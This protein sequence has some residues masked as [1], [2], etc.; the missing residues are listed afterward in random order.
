LRLSPALT[1]GVKQT[2]AGN[3]LVWRTRNRFW[4]LMFAIETVADDAYR[5]AGALVVNNL[6][7]C[8]P[9][10][11]LRGRMRLELLHAGFGQ[12]QALCEQSTRDSQ[13]RDL[14]ERMREDAFLDKLEIETAADEEQRRLEATRVYQQH[15]AIRQAITTSPSELSPILVSALNS[16]DACIYFVSPQH[17]SLLHVAAS[18]GAVPAATALVNVAPDLVT[19][20]DEEGCMPLHLAARGDHV[21][22]IEVLAGSVAARST[23]QRTPLH[24]AAQR[25]CIAFARAL[26]NRG[27]D[28]DAADEDGRTPL[29]L[30]A[31]NN[32]AAVCEL[33]AERG[34]NQHIKA[35]DGKSAVDVLRTVNRALVDRL[36][37]VERKAGIDKLVATAQAQWLAQHRGLRFDARD[38]A[39]VERIREGRF[40]PLSDPLVK[41]AAQ[42]PHGRTMLALGLATHP[43]ATHED[44]GE[45]LVEQEALGAQQSPLFLL[46][47][48]RFLALRDGLVNA[49]SIA[50]LR[51]YVRVS[52]DDN[53]L[54]AAE[55]KLLQRAAT[56]ELTIGARESADDGAV[57]PLESRWTDLSARLSPA[58]RKP[59]DELLKLTGLDTVKKVALDVYAS[60]L[61][62][63]QLKAA[64]HGKAVSQETLNF[65]FLG[66]P[67]TGKTTVARLFAELLEQAGARAGHRFVQMT[68]SQAL[69]KGAKTFATEMAALTGSSKSVGPPP[70]PLRRGA[71]VEVDVGGKRYPAEI[72][73][74]D[75]DKKVYDVKFTDNTVEEKVAEARVR[76]VGEGQAVGGVLFLDEA[77]DLDPANNAEGR[78]ILAEIMSVAEDHRD[79]V[80]IILAG[81][82]D[83][84][85]NKLYAFNA[86]LP[87]RFQT[88][89][90]DDFSEDQLGQIWR[91]MGVEQG[92]SID[93]AVSRVAAARI[94]RGRGRK[95]FGNARSVRQMFERAI[96]EA[97]HRYTGGKPTMIV[98][99][100][101]GKEPTR[102]NV[103]ALDAVMR[104]LEAMVGLASVKRDMQSLVDLAR[105]NYKRELAGLK[106]DDVP[107]NR[108][109]LGNP[110]TGKTTVASLY[111]R[112][113][114]A[115]RFLSNGELVSKTASDF[116]GDVVGASQQKT[117]ALLEVAKGRV[118]LIDEAYVL[119]DSLYGKQALDTI[120][121]KVS[122]APGEDI[123]VVMCGYRSEMT[124]MLRDQ[125]P[126]LAR[127]FDVNFALQFDDLSDS[128]LL[129]VFTDLC[130]GAELRAPYDVRLHA[131]GVLAK[132]KRLP[133]FGNVGAA[134]TLFADAKK[135]MT[136]RLREKKDAPRRMTVEDVDASAELTR[137]PLQTLEKELAGRGFG[138]VERELRELGERVRV[139]KSEGSSLDGL[140]GNYI[141]TGAAGT[142]KTSVARTLGKILFA[143]GLLA[144]PDV[145]E[146]SATDLIG[147]YVGHSRKNVEEMMKAARGG[148]LFIDE[149]YGLGKGG[150]FTDEA[151]DQLVGMLTLPEYVGGKTVVI[152]A[153]YT[154]EMHH[155]LEK[156]V[157]LKS[158]FTETIPF[159][160]WA[161]KRCAELVVESLG[162]GAAPLKLR[163]AVNGVAVLERTFADL[164]ERPGWAN[165]RDA[166]Q[167]TKKVIDARLNRVAR[168][169]EGV[170]VTDRVVELCDIEEACRR[171]LAARPPKA[172]ANHKHGGI[173]EQAAA[174]ATTTA[175][176]AAPRPKQT[177]APKPALRLKQTQAPKP[178]PAV[179][180]DVDDKVAEDDDKEVVAEWQDLYKQ[181]GANAK[182][183][184]R[185][186]KEK[187]LDEAERAAAE[188]ELRRLAELR[189][190]LEELA[191]LEA[192]ARAAAEA[193]LQRERK[194]QAVVAKLRAMGTCEMGYC[195][196]AQG[197]GFRCAG[198]SHFVSY[199]HV[200]VS[201]QEARSMF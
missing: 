38:T 42:E 57:S 65:A 109:F 52:L 107:L 151:V 23:A 184:N 19:T 168:L 78:A 45:L 136:V 59:M 120:V 183:I 20:V 117:A 127:R 48:A 81:Y 89:Q 63:K 60:V 1:R 33:L 50:L 111:G 18:V 30:A 35:R 186:L 150:A 192:A 160:D 90:F 68:A 145:V 174:A 76:P 189:R 7:A 166:D 147:A 178:A 105:N 27:V 140:V 56:G 44:V 180:T 124:K 95:G 116:V 197:G 157:G 26:L 24:E 97:K 193:A 201:E 106:V 144:K 80:T 125:N 43:T 110:G 163:D 137:N 88:V 176:A 22:M 64:G 143:Y 171:L 77:Y 58:Q 102:E 9:D 91:S 142:G 25:N 119:D 159:G 122:G 134:K 114:R 101:I 126:G 195:W 55:K 141:F 162:G 28:F 172:A 93:D 3:E 49:T 82:K 200:D 135:R 158:R 179:A 132:M 115:L 79:T 54:T 153:G 39:T 188:K 13:L 121:E 92:W 185:L 29:I 21:G 61:A 87:S 149:A 70:R 104:E 118:L 16:R 199:G 72:V 146:T 164:L 96:G 14:F 51:E 66:N 170:T 17:G 152:L 165:A 69:R 161:P 99:D 130:R 156:N 154:D 36:E 73:L 191:R 75:A 83:D 74:A 11:V 108:L 198:G 155:M 53:W 4:P 123:A 167:L 187:K 6:T 5:Y 182:D 196:I 10:V 177:Q 31:H 129:Q 12:W 34:A 139:L 131:V 100:V 32:A 84:I 133:N 15:A 41:K 47:Y 37:A 8:L 169:P 85:E 148:V 181:L 113:L 190:K 71:N 175:A 67:G 194:R 103:P 40:D 138:D 94:A 46:A 128:E 98:E 62:N 112:L 2:V 173:P 86:G